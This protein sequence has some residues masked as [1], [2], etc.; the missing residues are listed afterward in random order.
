MRT[1]KKEEQ[2]RKLAL[3]VSVLVV[4][5]FGTSAWA[6]LTNGSLSTPTIFD[7]SA[8]PV[9]PYSARTPVANPP[10]GLSATAA[11]DQYGMLLNWNITDN[12][13]GTYTYKYYFGPG[14][15]PATQP[16]SGSADDPY[17]ANKNML[18]WDIQLGSGITNV[19]QLSSVS[20]NVYQFDGQK[21]GS[22][23]ATHWD[24]YVDPDTGNVL[25]TIVASGNATVLNIGNLQG[26]TGH[27]SAGYKTQD[28]FY[29]LRWLMPRDDSSIPI[30]NT[31]ANF[32]LTFT[33]TYAPGWG[34]F[35]ANSDQTK[36]NNDY[37]EVVAFDGTFDATGKLI[38]TWS[39]A[40][41]VA[42]GVPPAPVP[43]PPSILL[44]GSGLLGM[45]VFKRRKIEV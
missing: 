24:S 40:V 20:W 37:S 32:D 14:W 16:T 17:V 43:V 23:T 10:G 12:S 38:A 8:Y 11:W 13:N 18:A 9:Q 35:F 29:G 42:G 4:F 5:A 25:N 33:S 19:D 6:S 1:Q 36:A 31:N 2:M 39:N 7:S 22:G 15:Y 44:L 28:L 30:W 34:D 27:K 21:I 26:K 41:A 3:L 45:G